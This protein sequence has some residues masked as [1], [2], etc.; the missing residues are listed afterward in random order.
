MSQQSVDQL[1]QLVSVLQDPVLFD[2]D[3]TC[4]ETIE[5]HISIVLLTG[6]YAYKFKKPV[7]LGFVDFTDLDKR[8]HYCDEE[9]R[10]NRRLAPDLYLDVIAIGGS[11]ESP[12]L[13]K[14]PAIEY[15]VKMR[16]F[17]HE[18]ELET[19][20][21]NGEID[22]HD[23]AELAETIAAFHDNAD[24]AS[25][26]SS[27][28][29]V[30]EVSRQCLDNFETIGDG[31]SEPDMR[32]GLAT[33]RQWTEAELESCAPLI[34]E[35]H[36]GGRIR[37]C[38]GDMHITN[39]IW[40]D[41]RI[42]V[43][44]CIEFNEEFRWIDVMSEIAFLLM[45]L[46][47]RGRSDLARVFLNAYL[48]AGGD[49]A[50]VPLLRLFRV[51]RSMVRAKIA[52]LRAGQDTA[53]RSLQQRFV[54][55]VKLARQYIQ[56]IT[57]P[58]VVI[59]HGFSGS[60]KTTI[61]DDLIPVTGAVRVRSDIERKRLE[62]LSAS[63]QSHSGIGQG[64]YDP[65]HTEQTYERLAVCAESIIEAGLPVI[66][67]ATFLNADQRLRFRNLAQSHNVPFRI[68]D[69]QAPEAVLRER[70]RARQQQARDASEADT[71]VL[72][73][74]LSSA[75]G[76][77]APEREFVVELDTQQLPDAGQIA[78]RLRLQRP[79]VAI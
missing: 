40:L 66:V 8:R 24:A 29:T 4:F 74:Q 78:D 38:H 19:V 17:P 1:R 9:L 56:P 25:P 61:T 53:D 36:D 12:Q 20:L 59:T 57:K 69:C 30:G 62:G 55:H 11:I 64:L 65:T 48:E 15:C 31:L 75:D 32:A 49:Y 34:T 18:A 67:D 6:Q 41:N 51:Y 22:W 16:Q 7:D 27:F 35:R 45:D 28:G 21:T 39:M 76:F 37:E 70:I 14:A 73:R 52:F 77:A 13:S 79:D 23:F 46:D 58:A 2:H 72:D 68:L 63:E 26:D 43:F 42:Q 50:G 71:A 44:D 33:L 54:S 10:L 60:G 5:T 47:M 3:V